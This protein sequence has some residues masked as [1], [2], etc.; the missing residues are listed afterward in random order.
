V[1]GNACTINS[2]NNY[3]INGTTPGKVVSCF[4]NADTPTPVK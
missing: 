2:V 4:G 3:L 1:T